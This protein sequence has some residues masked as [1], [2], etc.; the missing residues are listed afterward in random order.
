[1]VD[2]FSNDSRRHAIYWATVYSDIWNATIRT[3]ILFPQRA[4]SAN[5]HPNILYFAFCMY[6]IN[7]LVFLA[8]WFD[9]MCNNS[10]V[11]YLHGD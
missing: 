8:I 6:C 3:D 1:M 11:F 10:P 4:N 9:F 7:S 5:K 2:K